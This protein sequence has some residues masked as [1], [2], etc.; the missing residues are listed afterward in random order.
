MF[1]DELGVE[2]EPRTTGQA[3][4]ALG[5]RRR[6]IDD[7]FRQGGEFERSS[8]H[9]AEIGSRLY[10]AVSRGRR[11]TARGNLM[12]E[13]FLNQKI[14]IDLRS[15]YVCFGTLKAIDPHFLDVKNADFHDLRDTDTTRENYVA[16]TR[17]TGI[18]RNRKRVLIRRD[19][20]VA[21][22]KL[23]DIVEV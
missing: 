10:P 18:K 1:A 19:E 13:E 3:R 22:T 21:I 17:L 7:R 9:E 16:A 6:R 4:E 2:G 11:P 8:R 14:V 5:E 15:E 23:E 20:V 12:I